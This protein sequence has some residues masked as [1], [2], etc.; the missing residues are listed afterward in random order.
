MKDVVSITVNKDALDKFLWVTH[1]GS[2]NTI[3]GNSVKD[4]TAG[5]ANKTQQNTKQPTKNKLV[6]KEQQESYMQDCA[7]LLEELRKEQEECRAEIQKLQSNNVFAQ[8]DDMV[9]QSLKEK[10]ENLTQMILNIEQSHHK[11]QKIKS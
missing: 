7:L 9:M 1:F 10:D 2:K 6:S 3:G 4:A 8:D 5:S 11:L